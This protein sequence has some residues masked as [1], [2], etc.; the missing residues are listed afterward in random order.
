MLNAR[1]ARV[2][3]ATTFRKRHNGG[4]RQSDVDRGRC[5]GRCVHHGMDE[6]DPPSPVTAGLSPRIRVSG[7]FS[8]RSR[9]R[10]RRTPAFSTYRGLDSPDGDGHGAGGVRGGRGRTAFAAG[11]TA[12]HRESPTTAGRTPFRKASFDQRLPDPLQ[13]GWLI[14]GVLDLRGSGWGE[15]AAIFWRYPF[16]TQRLQVCAELP[17]PTWPESRR[18]ESC[19]ERP[20]WEAHSRMLFGLLLSERLG[21]G[22]TTHSIF[23]GSDQLPAI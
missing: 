4:R 7:V 22:V 8:P 18:T 13:R 17:T 20:T 2:T 15:A 6:L 3:G 10:R 12:R 16:G 19:R 23:R 5:V 1:V 14:P 9:I 11:A 21:G